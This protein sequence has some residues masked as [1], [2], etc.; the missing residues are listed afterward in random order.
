MYNPLYL[1]LP[2]LKKLL[3]QNCGYNV[4]MLQQ[5]CVLLSVAEH[6]EVMQLAVKI[7]LG[8]DLGLQHCLETRQCGNH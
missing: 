6:F 3:I 7:V 1:Y 5:N 4:E 8:S 2:G